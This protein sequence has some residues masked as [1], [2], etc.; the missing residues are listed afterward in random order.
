MMS[1]LIPISTLGQQ[2]L[3]EGNSP[4]MRDTAPIPRILEIRNDLEMPDVDLT[5][6]ELV[7]PARMVNSKSIAG[8]PAGAGWPAQALDGH[9]LKIGHC[10][11]IA[12]MPP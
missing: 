6:Q 9:Y 2:M 7:I 12:A 3:G 1:A 10:H 11:A 8:R 5:P 4:Q